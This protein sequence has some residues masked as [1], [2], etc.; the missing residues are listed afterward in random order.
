VRRRSIFL[1]LGLLASSVGAGAQQPA[2][3]V[4]GYLNSLDASVASFAGLQRG[5]EEAGYAVGRDAMIA[6]RHSEGEYDRLPSMAADLVAQRV[7]VIVCAGLPAALAAKQATS[8]LPIVFV[9]GADPVKHGLVASL[10]RP[11]GNIT[12]VTQL[13]GALGSKRLELLHELVPAATVIGVLGNPRNPNIEDHL[14][15]VQRGARVLGR[16]VHVLPAS[17]ASEIEA[18]LDRLRGAGGGA[19]LILDDPL[20]RVLRERI[21]ALAAQHRLPTMHFGNDFVRAGGLLSYGSS[22]AENMRL[23]AGYVARILKGE[24]PS[25][26]PVLQPTAFELAINVAAAKAIGITVPPALLARADEVIE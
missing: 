8:T 25:D 15:E 1:L 19:L 2:A 10:S 16:Q 12:G 22:G 14:A 13:Y 5:L 17:S 11:G 3:P 24:K 4:I 20:F 23:A 6:M 7:A 21:V 9:S 18:A 26:L